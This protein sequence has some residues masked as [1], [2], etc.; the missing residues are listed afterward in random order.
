M[1]FPTSLAIQSAMMVRVG[2]QQFA[3]PTVSVEAIGRLDNFK[4]AAMAGQPAII[5]R[6]DP[7]PLYRLAEYLSLPAAPIDDKAQ[8][9]LV[10]AAGQRVALVVDEISGKSDIVMKNLGP[11]LRQVHG[12]AGGTVLG[13]GRV[14]LVLELNDLLSARARAGAH[15]AAAAVPVRRG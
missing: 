9:L 7:Y 13:N 2:G 10:N 6:N 12:I 11:H 4:R 14:V 8:L 3:I 15:L 5:V 1:T